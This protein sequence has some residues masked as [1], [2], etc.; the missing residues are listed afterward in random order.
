MVPKTYIKIGIMYT[1]LTVNMFTKYSVNKLLPVKIS[2]PNIQ[3]S[4]IRNS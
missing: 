4:N 3:T 2:P 1:Q